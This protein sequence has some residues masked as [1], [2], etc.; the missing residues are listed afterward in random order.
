MRPSVFTLFFI[1]VS[2][3]WG[4]SS[5]PGNDALAISKREQSRNGRPP[6]YESEFPPPP[7]AHSVSNRR[8]LPPIHLPSGLSQADLPPQAP[9]KDMKAIWENRDKK[10]KLTG[11]I[12]SPVFKMKQSS[13]F[14]GQRILMRKRKVFRS[15]RYEALLREVAYLKELHRLVEW[16]MEDHRST[17][18]PEAY[19]ATL[20]E[21][22]VSGKD[23]RLEAEE[24]TRLIKVAQAEYTQ[25]GYIVDTNPNNYVFRHIGNGEYVA[26]FI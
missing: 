18:S 2:T 10:S 20:D 12:L 4:A 19:I 6:S 15:K 16:A 17:F 5:V 9:L 11:S 8:V 22:Y 26:E 24:L 13:H 1:V 3:T 14:T 7:P 25:S 23:T 21:G